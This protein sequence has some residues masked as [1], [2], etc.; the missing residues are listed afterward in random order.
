VTAEEAHRRGLVSELVED[1]RL[2]DRA[3]EL[4][5]QISAHSALGVQ[6]TKRALQLNTDAPGLDAALEVENR[7][8]VIT[9]ATSEAAAA[10]ARWAGR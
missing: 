10:R 5:G 3:L 2:L 7:N 4:A 9:H 1:D 6:M 8:Q